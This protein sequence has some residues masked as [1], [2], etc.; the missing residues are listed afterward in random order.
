MEAIEGRTRVPYAPEVGAAV[1]GIGTGADVAGPWVPNV[2]PVGARVTGFATGAFVSLVLKTGASVTGADVTG[3]SVTGAAV[4][5]L[6]TFR[7]CPPLG[8]PNDLC[9]SVA[10]ANEDD[11]QRV[12]QGAYQ[13]S[14][15]QTKGSVS[16]SN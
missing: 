5:T 15:P 6:G 4:P 1:V 13:K 12:L 3:A 9:S 10:S 8:V 2:V 7:H 14:T 11:S 16:K